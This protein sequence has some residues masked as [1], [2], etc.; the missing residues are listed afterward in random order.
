M[1][2]TEVVGRR[3]RGRPKD[4]EDEGCRK[5]KEKRVKGVGVMKVVGRRK[6]GRPKGVKDEGCR[7]EEERKT[8]GCCKCRLQEGV[9]KDMKTSMD[10]AV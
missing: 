9:R 6:R 1:L 10:K 8:K 7:K 3:R 2:E 5:G 4:A